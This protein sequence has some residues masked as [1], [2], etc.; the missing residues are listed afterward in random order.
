MQTGKLWVGLIGL[1][2]LVGV[3]AV[4]SQQETP[5][6]EH[7]ERRA[8]SERTTVEPGRLIENE[9]ARQR[10]FAEWLDVADEMAG[11]HAQARILVDFA[12][13]HAVPS[14]L[15]PGGMTQFIVLGDLNE[16]LRRQ[17]ELFASPSLMAPRAFEITVADMARRRAYGMRALADWQYDQERNEL[18]VP[19]RTSYSRLYGAVVLLH[20]L[21][22]AYDLCTGAEPAQP[23]PI[24]WAQGEAR[25]YSVELTILD[26]AREGEASR[27]AR[28]LVNRYRSAGDT[29][30]IWTEDMPDID[31]VLD[32]WDRVI[33]EP[34]LSDSERNTR[35]GTLLILMNRLLIERESLGTGV[36]I[37]YIQ[38]TR[39]RSAV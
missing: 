17:T 2:C 25:A 9:A 26:T 32:Q 15:L 38:A 19:P 27:F 34:P 12:R 36:F 3:G 14:E 30:W 4:V 11:T 18:F 23:S 39:A 7:T 13:R 24:Q 5:R 31:P 16:A 20:E 21:Q 22:H 33:N 29:R 1:A 8:P 28:S 6:P 35:A 37:D 10:D